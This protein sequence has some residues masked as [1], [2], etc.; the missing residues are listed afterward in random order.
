MKY[1]VNNYGTDGTPYA[2]TLPRPLSF[3]LDH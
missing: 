3:F 2:P 1:K